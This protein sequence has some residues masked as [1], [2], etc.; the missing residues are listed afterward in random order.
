MDILVLGAYLCSMIARL[1]TLLAILA[2]TLVTTGI[3]AHAARMS[4]SSSPDHAAHVGDM[5]N[6]PDIAEL[7]CDG[8]RHCGSADAEICE[9]VC[10]GLSAFLT[11][12]GGEGGHACS[13]AKH[14]FP[15][16]ASDVGGA[17]DL[18]E[19]PPKSRLL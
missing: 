17:P 3:P 11:S 14:D 12:P 7:A 6:S 13:S 5:M 4:M 15:F 9:F 8:D 2:T 16:E 18:N 1:V 19:R 10:A